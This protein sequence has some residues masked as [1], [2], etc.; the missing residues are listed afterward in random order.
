MYS[1]LT[2]NNFIWKYTIFNPMM[3]II[4]C[5]IFTR[6]ICHLH[7][8]SLTRR[9]V[10]ATRRW[11]H[12]GE[13]LGSYRILSHFARSTCVKHGYVAKYAQ[14]RQAEASRWAFISLDLTDLHQN[15][16]CFSHLFHWQVAML[17][18]RASSNCAKHVKCQSYDQL[19]RKIALNSK[20][21]C[22]IAK[23]EDIS[24]CAK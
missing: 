4:F 20:C 18:A 12:Y 8:S 19:I 24:Y 22:D 21:R 16:G 6:I 2:S 10:F 9:E 3:S 14:V 11:D 5:N 15:L 1:K 17:Y 13:G 7:N 23:S